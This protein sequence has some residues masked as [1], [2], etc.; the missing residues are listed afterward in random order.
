MDDNIKATDDIIPFVVRPLQSGSLEGAFRVHLS[1]E[2]LERLKLKV[3]EICQ[4]TC[5]NGNT[6]YGIAWRATDKGRHLTS[7]PVKFQLTICA[8]CWMIMQSTRCRV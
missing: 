3:G 7:S 1:P 6:G 5:E 2:S 4:I 8:V